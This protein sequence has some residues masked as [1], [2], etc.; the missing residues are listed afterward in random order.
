MSRLALNAA[1]A[2][3]TMLLVV[4]AFA[5][6]YDMGLP[7]GSDLRSGF[8]DDW[9]MSDKDDPLTFELGA[10]YWYSWGRQSFSIGNGSLSESDQTHSAE[11]YFRIND[12][13]S[14]FY[15]KG[16]G[17]L[18]MRTSG[19]Y[20]GADNGDFT[21]GQIGYAG[22]DIGYSWL[23]DFKSPPLLRAVP[24]LHVLAGLAERLLDQ[25]GQ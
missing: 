25:L 17:G 16:I 23:G 14:K 19:S 21:D 13:S 7:E 15:A 10:R 18:S 22:A 24:R 11:T 5:A 8:N 3:A 6:D 9:S 1:T 2:L 12:N 20:S 4:P